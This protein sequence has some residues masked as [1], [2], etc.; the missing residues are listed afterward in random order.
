MLCC[1]IP[2][3][4]TMVLF[5]THPQKEGVRGPAADKTIPLHIYHKDADL[6]PRH[7]AI[8]LPACSIEQ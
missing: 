7:T 6:F 1:K 4:D 2:R 5:T 8:C 3:V